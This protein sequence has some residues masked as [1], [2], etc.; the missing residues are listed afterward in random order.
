MKTI[1][2]KIL[3]ALFLAVTV[4]GCGAGAVGDECDEAGAE[5][6]CEDGAACGKTIDGDVIC[7]KTCNDQEDC[8][9]DENCNG[10]TGAE[11]DEKACF[12]K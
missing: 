10:V 12:P 7:L 1:A 3:L 9:S 8:G 6:E 5:D 2:E 4:P 11:D